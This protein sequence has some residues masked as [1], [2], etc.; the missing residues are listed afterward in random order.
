MQAERRRKRQIWIAA[1]S[2]VNEDVLRGTNINVANQKPSGVS[3][4]RELSISQRKTSGCKNLV[5]MV[6]FILIIIII[7]LIRIITIIPL[8]LLMNVIITALVLI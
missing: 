2:H 1:H 7:L 5:Q 4:H 8:Y 6:I 3:R